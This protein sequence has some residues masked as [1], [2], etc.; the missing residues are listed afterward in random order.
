MTNPLALVE[1]ADGLR[2]KGHAECADAIEALVN[3]EAQLGTWVLW[4]TIDK[5]DLAKREHDR[6]RGTAADEPVYRPLAPG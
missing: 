6:K 1:L 4:E 3:A 5:H 2:E